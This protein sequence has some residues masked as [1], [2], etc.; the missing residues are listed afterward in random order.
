MNQKVT[1]DPSVK[2][3]GTTNAT[4][5][6]NN[7]VVAPPKQM[8]AVRNIMDQTIGSNLDDVSPENL[9][10]F[11]TAVENYCC[12]SE[13]LASL[14]K[15]LYT[16]GSMVFVVDDMMRVILWNDYAVRATGYSREEMAGRSLLKDLP[17]LI[18]PQTI[19]QLQ[20]ALVRCLKG[21]PVSGLILEFSKR[22]GTKLRY[23]SSC[24]PL[25]SN[26]AGNGMLILGQDVSAVSASDKRSLAETPAIMPQGNG[27]PGM[28]P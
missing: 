7:V 10:A 14:G 19:P 11:V 4:A 16:S 21:L 5:P 12:T 3:Y 2:G 18:P 25:L 27:A 8:T 20:D 13:S 24:A 15:S 23:L 9:K 17:H 22:D 6:P 26:P 1:F 28:F